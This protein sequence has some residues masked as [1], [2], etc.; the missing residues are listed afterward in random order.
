VTPANVILAPVGGERAADA[1]D[2]PL[3]VRAPSSTCDATTVRTVTLRPTEPLVPGRDY[4]AVVNPDGSAPRCGTSSATRPPRRFVSFRAAPSVEQTSAAV[5]TSPRAAWTGVARRAGLGRELRGRRTR[6]RV[7]S[8]DA[9]PRHPASTG[10]PSRGPNRGR[11]EIY[12]DGELLRLHD[13]YSV[14]R[15][16]GV[17]VHDRRAR[18]RCAP[19]AAIVATGRG[20]R[21][22]DRHASSRSTASTS[23][24]SSRA[25]RPGGLTGRHLFINVSGVAHS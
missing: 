25:G 8:G 11:A 23:S 12:V 22:L 15:T 7:R 9:V 16:F 14:T 2:L 10:P 3:G 18:R 24:T 5:T 17:V 6:R 19:T 4:E 13:L 21:A 1:A 20:R